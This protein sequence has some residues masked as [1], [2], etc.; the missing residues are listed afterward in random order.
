MEEHRTSET[1]HGHC[2]IRFWFQEVL[3]ILL[4]RAHRGDRTCEDLCSIIAA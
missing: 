2:E 1:V 3:E 4:P